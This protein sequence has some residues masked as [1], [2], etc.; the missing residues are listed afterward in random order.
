MNTACTTEL[1]LI[2][3]G[4]HAFGFMHTYNIKFNIKN[5]Q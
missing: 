1:V 5:V 2:N 3:T 4:E